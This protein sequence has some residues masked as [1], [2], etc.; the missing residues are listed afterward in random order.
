MKRALFIV[1][2]IILLASCST[3]YR[4]N[5]SPYE[6]ESYVGMTHEALVQRLGAPI[7]DVSDGGDGYI[8]VFEG[9]REIF[10]YSDR[11][12][13]KSSTLPKAQFYMNSDGVCY[14]VR[15]ANTDAIRV[16]SVGGTIALVLL[17]LLIF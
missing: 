17:L 5:Y 12:A 9:N 4:V 1:L 14:K 10:H 8:L 2:A 3:T 16:T 6:L 13:A 15:T 11:Y 7:S